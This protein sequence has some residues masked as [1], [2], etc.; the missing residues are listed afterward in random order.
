MSAKG[1]R[2]YVSNV[3]TYRYS[4]IPVFKESEAATTG[5]DFPPFAN[6]SLEAQVGRAVKG[7]MLPGLGDA[8]ALESNSVYVLETG[9]GAPVVRARVRTGV[10][11]GP[12]S[13]GGASPGGVAVGRTRVYV[14]NS[15]QDSV[16]A[17]QAATSR[18]ISTTRSSS[19]T[20][21][22]SMTTTRIE[23]SAAVAG[24]RGVIPLGLALSPDESRLYI[25]CAGINAVAVFDTRRN[26]VLGFIP[27][28]W[29]P[30]RVVVANHGH[31]LYVANAK[32][33]GA[34]PNGGDRFL[35]GLAGDQIGEITK[36]TVSII[37]V[38][39]D[40]E[41]KKMTAQVLHNN[42]IDHSAPPPSSRRADFP[43]PTNGAPSQL[44]HH[45]VLIVKEGWTYDEV[46]GDIRTMQ[47]MAVDGDPTLARW[48][49][50][51]D[52]HEPSQPDVYHVQVTPNHH[53]LAEKFGVSDNYY[54]D[55][56]SSFDGHHWLVD[57]YPMEW[58]EPLFPPL[59]GSFRPIDDDN[60]A[61][62]R[63]T[64]ASSPSLLPED[65]LEAGSL[66]DHLARHKLS[67]RN[68]GE[69]LFGDDADGYK[70]T[71]LRQGVNLPMPGPLYANTCR[72][73]PKFNTSIPDQY[74]FEQFKKDFEDRYIRG[75]Q[76]LPQFLYIV[77]PNDQT[78]TPRPED[79]YPY[80][81]SYVADNDLALGKMIDL[82]SHSKFWA[83][84]AVFV[85]EADA[86][87]GRDHVDA[88]RS[89]LLVVSPFSRR[90]VS[91]VHTSML[92][93]FKTTERILGIPPLNQYDAAATDLSDCFTD[94]PDMTPYVAL[95]S[96]LSIFDPDKARDP[97]DAGG[98]GAAPS[99][100]PD[101]STVIQ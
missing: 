72:T 35:K 55:S 36:G 79:G 40:A 10:A 42:G 66:W 33:Y 65:Y 61:P 80:R 74:R 16:S 81:A 84:M 25:A 77:L 8:N 37:P 5:L 50:N 43:V 34:G 62:G 75:L 4:V 51:A 52:A 71:G 38:P 91:H 53:A 7:K 69:G 45:V 78:A 12:R 98:D 89:V 31:T 23:P 21:H 13:V 6:G 90:G 64:M 95:P 46:L 86:Q 96:D 24:L 20:P 63:L 14:S 18:L 48:G 41:L 15:A 60:A 28:G 92:S 76:P 87:D 85:T 1:D 32:G 3:G 99:A 54:V 47:G 44:I 49:M 83:D 94:I 67:F 29:F 39:T 19:T 56:D 57:S 11:I 9:K 22:P 100:P 2:I 30:A 88:H 59:N 73:Y 93:I 26:A 82:L 58:L 70:P 17:F 68:Y 27:T 97:L 101:N